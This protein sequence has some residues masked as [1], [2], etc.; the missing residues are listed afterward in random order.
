[1]FGR[2]LAVFLVAL[3]KGIS[4]LAAA[5]G[6][7]LALLL[8]VHRTSDPLTLLFPGEMSE[9]PRDITVRWL[10]AHLPHPS[11]ALTLLIG[12]GLILWAL[13]LAAE[14]IGVWFDLGWGEFLIVMET[15]SFLPIEIWDLVRRP[16]ATGAVTFTINLLILLYVG[17]LLR[18]RVR[19]PRVR[20]R[21]PWGAG[22]AVVGQTEGAQAKDSE[23]PERRV[24]VQPH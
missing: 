1:M 24:G 2:P 13:L 9:T 14:S 5:G 21:A 19:R 16:Q 4:A 17:S 11:P 10:S 7:A 12:L 23:A 15:A 18:N 22:P 20:G 3:E 8:H 6:A